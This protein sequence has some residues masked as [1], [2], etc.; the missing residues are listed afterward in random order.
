MTF[1]CSLTQMYV[2]LSQ[3]VMYNIL[4]GIFVCAAATLFFVWV[5]IA[6][7]SVQYGI[8]GSTREM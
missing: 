7:V 1:V 2:F 6:R 5:V 8:A 4:L 3:Y